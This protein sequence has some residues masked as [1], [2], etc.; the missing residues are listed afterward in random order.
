MKTVALLPGPD[1][2]TGVQRAIEA[3]GAKLGWETT[4]GDAATLLRR[5]G[6]AL[7]GPNAPGPHPSTIN[8]L[9]LHSRIAPCRS[10]AGDVDV[11]VVWGTR[12]PLDRE[13]AWELSHAAFRHAAMEAR[14]RVT[15]VHDPSSDGLFREVALDASKDYPAIRTDERTAD[16]AAR[17]LADRPE[18]LDV[19]VCTAPVGD[20]LA[21]LVADPDL[22][23]VAWMGR[24]AAIFRPLESGDRPIAT[25]LA[26][27]LLLEHLNEHQACKRI[28]RAADQVLEEGLRRTAGETTE[29]ILAA[30][31]P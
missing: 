12:E 1:A 2:M 30:I 15:V 19:L 9:G 22:A 10:A 23:A 25:F 5:A 17:D 29:A 24:D 27:A 8:A 18:D 16:D 28:R 11:V 21:K 4:E 6:A 20:S 13:G 14:R 7:A 26:A 31:T 3:A